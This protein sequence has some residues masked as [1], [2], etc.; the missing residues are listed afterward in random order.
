[1]PLPVG[2]AFG[3]DHQTRLAFGGDR[4]VITDALDEA[5]IAAVARIGNHHV[6]ERALLGT[7][8]GKTNDNHGV[9]L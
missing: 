6:E 8:A 9:L 2:Q 3:V 7:A 4:I 5:A 1:M